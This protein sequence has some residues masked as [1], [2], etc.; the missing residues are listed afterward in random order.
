[1]V[2]MG[3]GNRAVKTFVVM[4]G[5]LGLMVNWLELGWF[6]RH[7]VQRSGAGMGAET[8]GKHPDGTSECGLDK[9]M[10]PKY[11]RMHENC[12]LHTGFVIGGADGL[13]HDDADGWLP[14]AA[15]SDLGLRKPWL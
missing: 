5:G 9:R 10:V 7:F 8:D 14:S 6:G 1:M 2:S 12:S 15:Q 3:F 13:Y 11:R 4:V